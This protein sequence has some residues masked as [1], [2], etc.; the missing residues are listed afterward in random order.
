MTGEIVMMPA[1][2]DIFASDAAVLVNPVDCT[3]AQGKGLAKA[4]ARRFPVACAEYRRHT[5][6]GRM[7]AGAVWVYDITR[8]TMPRWIFFAATK[9]HWRDA[10][11]IEDV[12]LCAQWINQHAVDVGARSVAVPALGCGEGGLLWGEVRPLL[13][14]AAENV[15]ALGIKVMIYA[16]HEDARRGGR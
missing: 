6:N 10:S 5:K 16:P 3:G 14:A 15:A 12:A 11:E 1:G 7:C 9:A 13:V 2:A 4:F 8:A